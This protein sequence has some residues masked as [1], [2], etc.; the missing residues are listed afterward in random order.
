V[1]LW[2]VLGSLVFWVLLPF[3][4]LLIRPLFYSLEAVALF[5]NVVFLLLPV[6]IIESVAGGYL[7]YRIFLRLRKGKLVGASI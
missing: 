4:S 1:K 6:I 5:A 7:G 2:S 3:F